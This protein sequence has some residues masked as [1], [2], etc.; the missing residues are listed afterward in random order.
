MPTEPVTMWIDSLTMDGRSGERRG[1]A[2]GERKEVTIRGNQG[3]A[4]RVTAAGESS[5]ER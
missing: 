3:H 2:D 5:R 4:A 1:R